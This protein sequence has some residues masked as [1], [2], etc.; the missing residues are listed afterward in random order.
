MQKR[1][2]Y[3]VSVLRNGKV[4]KVGKVKKLFWMSPGR[5]F[6]VARCAIRSYVAS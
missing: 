6:E 1:R 4:R 5:M 3:E 2:R